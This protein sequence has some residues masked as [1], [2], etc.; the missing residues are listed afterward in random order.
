MYLLLDE[1]HLHERISVL[2]PSALLCRV[3]IESEDVAV[4]WCRAPLAFGIE[5]QLAEAASIPHWVVALCAPVKQRI[6][7]ER[8]VRADF[9]VREI[10]HG[11]LL[12]GAW[13]AAADVECMNC[14]VR[15]FDSFMFWGWRREIC[16]DA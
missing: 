6:C 9:A 12:G 11:C 5:P 3:K 14:S 13:L 7:V 1:L 10:D 15:S 8:S 2:Y 16:R 4:Q